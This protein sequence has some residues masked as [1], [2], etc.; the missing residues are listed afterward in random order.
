MAKRLFGPTPTLTFFQDDRQQWN[1]RVYNRFG[2]AVAEGIRHH[3]TIEGAERDAG[4]TFE[5][6]LQSAVTALIKEST[7]MK[8]AIAVIVDS[9][10]EASEATKAAGLTYASNKPTK[11]G[12]EAIDTENNTD[13]E[14]SEARSLENLQTMPKMATPIDVQ[15]NDQSQVIYV[16]VR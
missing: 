15:Y 5:A 14:D 11:A 2:E 16:R 4:K 3:D 6:I 13:F 9:V 8:T 7:H 12:N 1:W 10:R